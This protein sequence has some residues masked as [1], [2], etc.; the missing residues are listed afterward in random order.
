MREALF[1]IHEDQNVELKAKNF[2]H[3]NEHINMDAAE[4]D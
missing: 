1:A 3:D 4:F 2:T